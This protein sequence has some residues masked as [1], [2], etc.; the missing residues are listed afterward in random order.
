MRQ[1]TLR[2][3]IAS[4]LL[5]SFS[6]L[7]L[8]LWQWPRVEALDGFW[9]V[10]LG[11]LRIDISLLAILS[12]LPLLASPWL[13]HRQHPAQ[14]TAYWYRF[15]WMLLVLMELATPQFIIEYD[16][17]PN[18]LFIAYLN[19]PQEVSAMLWQGYKLLLAVTTLLLFGFAVLGWKLF[20]PTLQDQPLR[21]WKRLPATLAVFLIALLA[22]R[23]TL[24]HRPLNAA[25][26][27]IGND[28]M[29]NMLP[30]N[31]LYTVI[32]AIRKQRKERASADLYG[33]MDEAQ[34][35][36]LV[37][38]AAGL[39]GD[40]ADPMRPSLHMHHAETTTKT[41]LNMVIIVEESLGAQYVASLGGQALTPALDA[42]AKEGWWFTRTYA[43]G[44]RSIRGLEALST[45]FLPTPAEAV[46]KQP[47]SQQGFFT[48][49]DLLGRVGYRSRFLYG[50]E[51]HFDN[52]KAFFL[53]NGF[54]EVIDLGKFLTK[55]DFVGS[56]GAADEDMFDEL[57][58][59]LMRDKDVPV[60][61]FAFT[62]SNHTPWEYPN[63][64]ISPIG[65]P[66]SVENTIRYAD[67]ALGQ[68]FERA[69]QSPYWE[70]TVFMV[71]ADHDARVTGASL[72][73]VARFHIPALILGASITPQR[74][75]R[76]ISQVDLPPTLLSLIGYRGQ[77]P[78]LG[79]DLTRQS[80]N[81]A[82]MQYGDNYGYLQG[83]QLM[84]LQPDTAP[85][86]FHYDLP[87]EKLTPTPV[88]STLAERALAHALWPSWAYFNQRY[89]LPDSSST[90]RNQE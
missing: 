60:F 9:P 49:A 88:D 87:Q 72:I 14:I 89:N 46:L 54:D 48:L 20:S 26:V 65:E 74:D 11:G 24:A 62:V 6:R 45:G 1:L 37:R 63:G 69:K 27:S 18:R 2:F 42:L 4:F 79:A 38:K 29:V 34:M 44:T 12:A 10:L 66:D 58:A 21:M 19:S 71:V 5:L 53:G 67:W 33:D 68:F 82:I 23:G 73:P 17:R 75:D 16:S 61:T 90:P 51:A 41:P 15:W 47:R 25:M 28:S 70:N 35:H 85:R 80:P 76:L 36:S 57:H 13:G 3:L 39:E 32:D 83:D 81:R 50:G 31:S 59:R 84:V 43:T 30:L 64:R 77:H 56:W 55:P 7:G 40:M 78:M 52:M 22:A 86:Q 8:S